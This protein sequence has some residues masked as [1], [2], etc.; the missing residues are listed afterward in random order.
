MPEFWLVVVGDGPARGRLA[1]Y[2]ADLRVSSRVRFVG[3]V[4]DPVLY[5]W[6]RTARV[7]VTLGRA[8]APGH[9]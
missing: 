5:R 1:A 9:R 7:V 6:L 4:P 2:A 3:A 8:A